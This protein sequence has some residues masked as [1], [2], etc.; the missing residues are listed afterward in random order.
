MVATLLSEQGRSCGGAWLRIGGTG[1]GVSLS[2][3]LG[4][5]GCATDDGGRSFEPGPSMDAASDPVVDAGMDAVVDDGP[6]EDADVV[7]PPEP[8]PDVSVDGPF[9]ITTEETTIRRGNRNVDVAVHMPETRGAYPMVAFM[10][11][12]QLKTKFYLPLIHRWASHGFIV[13]R[14]D[15]PGGLF[16][17]NHVEMTS[18]VQFAIDWAL[19]QDSVWPIHDGTIAVAGHSLGGKL[20]TMVTGADERIAAL[21]GIDPVNGGNPFSGFNEEL[22]DV[23]PG[24]VEGRAIP[25]AFFGELTD[26]GAGGGGQACAPAEGN[27]AHFFS[28]ATSS[29]WVVSW[30]IEGADHMDF[31]FDK[32]GCGLNCGL[33]KNGEADEGSV[34]DTVSRLSTAFLLTHLHHIDGFDELMT[35]GELPAGVNVM[36]STK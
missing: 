23:L 12:F 19:E 15:A 17:V 30:E 6:T 24:A 33:C 34:R 14:V 29:P 4:L 35:G 18:D 11:G 1:L 31:V 20:A 32:A 10:P 36:V 3:L 8:A 16:D 25:M 28:A 9:A 22:P 2:L 27:F 7:T 5:S 13:V 26:S 21:L